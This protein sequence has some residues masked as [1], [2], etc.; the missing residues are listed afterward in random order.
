M[1][2]LGGKT[3]LHVLISGGKRIL[4]RTADPQRQSADWVGE[5]DWWL[6]IHH[7][8]KVTQ[9]KFSHSTCLM[10]FHRMY[11]LLLLECLGWHF[12]TISPVVWEKVL[13]YWKFLLFPVFPNTFFNCWTEWNSQGRFLGW[14]EKFSKNFSPIGRNELFS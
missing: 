11:L 1:I 14:S 7:H 10:L 2:H 8:Q 5:E 9:G 3:I 4:R 6:P 13:K 12:S